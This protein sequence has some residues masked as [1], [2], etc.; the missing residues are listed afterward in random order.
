MARQKPRGKSAVMTAITDATAALISERGANSITL[1]DIAEKANVNHA[2][3]IRHFGSK[4]KLVRTVGLSLVN[5]M[6]EETRERK[7]NLLD[8]LFSWDNRYSMNIRAIVRIMLEDPDGDA[9]VDA[10]PLITRL[11]DW[12]TEGKKD[13]R[14]SPEVDSVV[15]VFVFACLVFGDELFG[16]YLSKIMDIPESAYQQM[17]PKIFETVLSGLRNASLKIS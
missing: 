1:R 5:A 17:R 11:L 16:P 10:R 7:E 8:I 4:E 9:L 15:L 12:I 6:I 14:I 3:I 13:L 2:L